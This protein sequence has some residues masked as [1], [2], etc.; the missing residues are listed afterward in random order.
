MLIILGTFTI[1]SVTWLHVPGLLTVL[2]GRTCLVNLGF[3]SSCLN[4]NEQLHFEFRVKIGICQH[5]TS[6][7]KVARTQ[8][9]RA[10]VKCKIHVTNHQKPSCRFLHVFPVLAICCFDRTVLQETGLS[11]NG[12]TNVSWANL[13]TY[14][15]PYSI[16]SI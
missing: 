14:A 3:C 1:I 8:F 15:I 4:G 5:V 11:L 6:I 2:C 12:L 10:N 7:A 16:Y 13:S 9:Y